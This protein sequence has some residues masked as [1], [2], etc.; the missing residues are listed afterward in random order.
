MASIT[1]ELA[2]LRY[3]LNDLQV[4]HPQLA[5]L[6]CD[7]QAA[8]HIAANPIYHERTKHIEIDCHVVRERIQSGAIATSHVPSACQLAD[9]FTKPL[10][11]SNFHSLLNKLEHT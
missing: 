7:S 9:L 2:W 3:L 4:E 6:F 1:C 10:G 11:T 8:L 5:K